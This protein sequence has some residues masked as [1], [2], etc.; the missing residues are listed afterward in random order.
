[1]EYGSNCK[2]GSKAENGRCK[3]KQRENGGWKMALI[4]FKEMNAAWQS[5]DAMLN[6]MIT[7]AD[8]FCPKSEF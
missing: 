3:P 1:M 6:K 4:K 5:I 8:D 7:R 2:R